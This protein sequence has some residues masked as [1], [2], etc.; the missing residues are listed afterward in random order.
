MNWKNLL[1]VRRFGEYLKMRLWRNAHWDAYL[2]HTKRATVSDARVAIRARM[3][4]RKVGGGFIFVHRMLLEFFAAAS[5]RQI[6]GT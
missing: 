1:T 6:R 5:L 3:R 2:T 4:L